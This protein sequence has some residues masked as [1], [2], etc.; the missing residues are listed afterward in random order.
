MEQRPT[1]AEVGVRRLRWATAGHPM[2]V[3]VLADGTVTDLDSP[4]GPPLGLDHLWW[5]RGVVT[6]Q[7]AGRS[8]GPGQPATWRRMASP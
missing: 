4:V 6:R 8:R 3:L 5:P 2:P 1:D 7:E